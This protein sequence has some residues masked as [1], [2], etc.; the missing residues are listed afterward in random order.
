MAVHRVA[1][2]AEPAAEEAAPSAEAEAGSPSNQAPQWQEMVAAGEL[3]PLEERLPVNPKVLEPLESIGNMA[4]PCAIRCSVPGPLASTPSW[5][6]R[7][8]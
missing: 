2:A 4:A 8:W 5:A 3:P 1:P 7:T 6:T